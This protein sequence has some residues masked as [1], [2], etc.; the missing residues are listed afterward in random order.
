MT[1]SQMNNTQGQDLTADEEQKLSALAQMVP[2]SSTQFTSKRLPCWLSMDIHLDDIGMYMHCSVSQMQMMMKRTSVLVHEVFVVSAH[3]DV[4]WKVNFCHFTSCLTVPGLDRT[5][6][7]TLESYSTKTRWPP[8]SS[9]AL[10]RTV[11]SASMSA[12]NCSST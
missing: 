7:A 2:R 9:T 1:E 8:S 3:L 6:M 10:S 4:S 12:R 5:R 11:T